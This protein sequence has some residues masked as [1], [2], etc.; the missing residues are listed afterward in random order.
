MYYKIWCEQSVKPT[1]QRSLL[2]V[3]FPDLITM[4]FSFV[5]LES[6]KEHRKGWFAVHCCCVKVT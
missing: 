1:V 5:L 3:I 6:L 2:F 4:L